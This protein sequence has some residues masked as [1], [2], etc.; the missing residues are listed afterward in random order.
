MSPF[1]E[2]GQMKYS[3]LRKHFDFQSE[4][5]KLRKTCMLDNRKS[6]IIATKLADIQ[7]HYL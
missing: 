4:T 7:Q 2:L 6:I 5:I 3:L 1:K